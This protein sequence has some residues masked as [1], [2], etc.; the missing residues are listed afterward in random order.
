VAN[1]LE[2]LSAQ[3]DIVLID[4]PPLLPMSDAAILA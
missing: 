3:Y 1:L 2:Q 4:T